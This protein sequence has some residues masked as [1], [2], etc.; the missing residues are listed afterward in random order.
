MM[1][2]GVWMA[3]A[4]SF[5]LNYIFMKR[6]WIRLANLPREDQILTFHLCFAFGDWRDS[7]QVNLSG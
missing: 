6:K 4:A 3:L 5:L 2:Q 1:I 7:K